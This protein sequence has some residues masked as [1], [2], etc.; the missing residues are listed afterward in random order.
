M[1]PERVSE[2]QTSLEFYSADMLIIN[3]CDALLIYGYLSIYYS[4]FKKPPVNLV[5]LVFEYIKL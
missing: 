1:I 5:K 3:L 4:S 2:K